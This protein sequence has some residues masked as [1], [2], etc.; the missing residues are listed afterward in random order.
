MLIFWGALLSEVLIKN[1]KYLNAVAACVVIAQGANAA[2]SH[3]IRTRRS[4]SMSFLRMLCGTA[5]RRAER[6]LWNGVA[7]RGFGDV[8]VGN[9][10]AARG[11]YVAPEVGG[12]HGSR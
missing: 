11:I 10:D 1:C 2:S 3:L 9:I 7:R 5:I 12:I 8:D 4:A 6:A